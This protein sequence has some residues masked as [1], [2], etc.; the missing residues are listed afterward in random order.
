MSLLRARGGLVVRA[1]ERR[2]RRLVAREVLRGRHA[3]VV[4]VGCEDGWMSEAWAP[5]A[6]RVVLVDVD[7]VPL[8]A[9]AGRL[10]PRVETVVADATDARAIRARLPRRTADVVVLSALLEHVPHPDRAL[11]ALAPCLRP[12]GRFVVYVPAD[13]PILAAK[14]LLRHAHLGALASGVS[15][16]PAPGHLHVFDRASLASLLARHGRVASLAFDP[17]VLGYLGVVVPRPRTPA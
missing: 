10:G 16:D 3:C 6:R 17:L 11:A 2:R 5:R 14:G 15:L 4:D 7:P 9:A 13:R 1:V 8:A 12:G